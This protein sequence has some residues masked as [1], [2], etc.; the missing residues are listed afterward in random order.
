MLKNISL[1]LHI[2]RSVRAARK[3][4][5]GSNDKKLPSSRVM[6]TG[7]ARPLPIWQNSFPAYKKTF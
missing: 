7:S 2:W 5:A 3:Q 1:K 4:L 6:Q